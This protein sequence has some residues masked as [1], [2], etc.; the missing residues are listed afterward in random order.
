MPD[1]HSDF[2]EE[3][4]GPDTAAS[5]QG[6]AQS[7]HLTGAGQTLQGSQLRGAERWA[8]GLSCSCV[9]AVELFAGP[10]EAWEGSLSQ[11]SALGDSLPWSPGVPLWGLGQGWPGGRSS[12]VGT[13]PAVR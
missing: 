3:L 5:S 13:P 4:V 11:R 2:W 12:K 1:P 9:E 8:Q 6:R 7:G 10:W